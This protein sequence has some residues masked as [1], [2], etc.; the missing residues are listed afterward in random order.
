[1]ARPGKV[2]K[3][4]EERER[5]LRLDDELVREVGR[6]DEVLVRREAVRVDQLERGGPARPADVCWLVGLGV[7]S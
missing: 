5:H 7:V 3:V 6:G 4:V 1:M 2:H